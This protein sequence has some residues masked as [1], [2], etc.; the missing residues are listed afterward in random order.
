MPPA[1]AGLSGDDAR[2]GAGGARFEMSGEEVLHRGFVFTLTRATFRDPEGASFERDVVRHPGA[3]AVVAVTGE[4]SVVLVRQYRPAFDRWLLEL[5]AGI[6]D[7][8]DEPE[9]ATAAR[10]L[11]EEAGYAASRFTLLTRCAVTPGFCDEV[12]AVFLATGLTQVAY[13]RHGHEERHMEVHEVPL[14]RFDALVDDGT[15]VDATTILGVG[16]A[17]RHL[18]AGR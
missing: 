5:P 18:S 4:R 9:E 2:T 10:E 8:A 15:I 3:V 13:D 17:V 14:H 16:L 7:V 6:C 1:E 12:S 11:G